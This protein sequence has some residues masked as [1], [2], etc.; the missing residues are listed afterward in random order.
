MESESAVDIHKLRA[1]WSEAG[2]L[3]QMD[4]LIDLFIE[5]TAPDIAALTGAVDAGDLGAASHLAH[6][7]KSG[8]ASLYA[9]GLSKMLAELEKEAAQGNSQIAIR[10][11]GRIPSE[12][13]AVCAALL[14]ARAPQK[15][16]QAG[17]ADAG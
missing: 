11:A 10:L 15:P 9:F 12:F 4:K 3:D 1:D 16:G 2:L 8:A 6:K 17:E 14:Q 5:T 7:L 13:E